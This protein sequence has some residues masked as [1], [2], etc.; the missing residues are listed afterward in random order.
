MTGIAF[1]LGVLGFVLIARW[2]FINDRLKTGSGEQGLLAMKN[3]AQE[4]EGPPRRAPRW[5]ATLERKQSG[6][7]R[8]AKQLRYTRQLQGRLTDR[9]GD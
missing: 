6:P 1:L 2:T 7:K 9:R 3:A 8:P 5:A 4:A